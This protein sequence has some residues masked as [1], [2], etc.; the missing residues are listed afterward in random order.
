MLTRGLVGKAFPPLTVNGLF[1]VLIGG[2]AE[3]G[4]LHPSGTLPYADSAHSVTRVRLKQGAFAQRRLP[5]SI[6][7]PITG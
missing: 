7:A 1:D 4:Q 6:L 2:Q 3:A 5:E